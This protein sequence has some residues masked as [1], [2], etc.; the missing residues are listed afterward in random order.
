MSVP[1]GKTTGNQDDVG[2]PKLL[3]RIELPHL[4]FQEEILISIG[5]VVEAAQNAM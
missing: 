4:A 3:V 2:S 5:V 1:I